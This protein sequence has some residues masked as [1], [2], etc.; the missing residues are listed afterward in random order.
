MKPE[1]QRKRDAWIAANQ[2]TPDDRRGRA[3]YAVLSQA[4]KDALRPGWWCDHIESFETPNGPVV[5]SQVYKGRLSP[6]QIDELNTICD[7]HG[8]VARM[9]YEHW[10]DPAETVLI[11]FRK[12]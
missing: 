10:R 9:S 7:A 8:I 6:A 1:Q 4:A 2:A 11:E 5:V 12:T 3:Y